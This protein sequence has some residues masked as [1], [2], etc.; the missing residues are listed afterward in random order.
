MTF[1][2]LYKGYPIWVGIIIDLCFITFFCVASNL[3]GASGCAEFSRFLMH[4][5]G[6]LNSKERKNDSGVRR[7]IPYKR[8][9]EKYYTSQERRTRFL[10][11]LWTSRVLM[12]LMYIWGIS[13]LLIFAAALII[14]GELLQL[15]SGIIALLSAVMVIIPNGLAILCLLPFGYL[16]H[17]FKNGYYGNGGDGWID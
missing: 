16:R 8:G 1:V 2:D 6:H 4:K 17:L 3:Y 13:S 12:I 15:C 10:F 5:Y 7:Y 14:K 11:F 9:Y